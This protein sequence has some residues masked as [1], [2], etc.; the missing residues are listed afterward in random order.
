MAVQVAQ[1]EGAA[2]DDQNANLDQVSQLHSQ[3][4][5]TS[6]TL[7]VTTKVYTLTSAIAFYTRNVDR[8]LD[9]GRA[10]HTEADC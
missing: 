5:Q 6:E 2:S 4:Q 3:L 7:E 9:L 10:T 8:H 1:L